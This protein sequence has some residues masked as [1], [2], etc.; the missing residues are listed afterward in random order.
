MKGLLWPSHLKFKY[1]EV[2]DFLVF[3]YHVIVYVNHT[4][5]EWAAFGYFLWKSVMA[6]GALA[7]FL[8]GSCKP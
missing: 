8:F 1:L 7:R 3:S 5:R 4:W 2:Q 6:F